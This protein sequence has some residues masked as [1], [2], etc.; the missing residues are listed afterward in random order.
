MKTLLLLF[1]ACLILPAQDAFQVKVS[2][3]GQ[4]MILIP[5]LSSG[6]ETWDSTVA[7]YKDRFECHVLTVAGFNGVPRVPAPML[8]TVRD[9][10]ATYIR[11][12]KLAKPVIVGHSLGGF[13]A[14]ELGS[15]YPDLVGPLVIVDSYPFMAGIADPSTTS[16][17]AKA[18]AAEMR[19]YMGNQSQ[20]MYERY[21]KSGIATRM[22]TTKDSDFER[23][24]EWGLKSDRSAVTDAMA[25]MFAA[26][27]RADLARIK[28]RTLVLGSWIG[29]KEYTD[30]PKTLA[31][32][33][34]Q[35][36]KLPDVQIRLN[37]TARHF[38][39]WDD[40]EWMFAHI[41]AFLN[42]GAAVSAR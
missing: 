18:Q 22:M 7:H 9:S 30:G 6:G 28:S 14:L 1:T 38:I 27:L 41:D 25:E 11:D 5:G 4:P 35:Y 32:L 15:K 2:G 12:K 13:L 23:L 42:N 17:Q 36:S 21:V 34:L 20:D 16:E 37:D 40:P 19:K 24:I 26:D 31:N 10:V 3:H 29:Y 39:M 33:K 8:D